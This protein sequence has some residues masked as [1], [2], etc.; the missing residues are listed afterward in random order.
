MTIDDMAAIHAAAFD[1]GRAWSKAELHQLL[2]S[3]DTFS[4]TAGRAFAIG[5][6]IA[7]EAELLTLATA[8]GSRRKGLGRACLDAF[9]DAAAARGAT[10]IF[11]E[12]AADNTAALALY[13]AAGFDHVGQRKGYYRQGRPAP[14]DAI[15]MRYSPG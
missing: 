6:V 13:G 2:Q 10:A 7:G 5:R 1:D 4:V 14:V 12:V 15:T 9:I 8:P 3:A 11:L